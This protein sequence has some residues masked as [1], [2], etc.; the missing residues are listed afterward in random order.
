[1]LNTLSEIADRYASE[2]DAT[3][4]LTFAHFVSGLVKRYQEAALEM[5]AYDPIFR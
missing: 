4:E 1:M 3:P 2:P 5:P